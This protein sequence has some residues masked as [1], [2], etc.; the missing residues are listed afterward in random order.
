MVQTKPVLG[1]WNLLAIE[2]IVKTIENKSNKTD[3]AWQVIKNNMQV[4]P[5]VCICVS[6][7]KGMLVLTSSRLFSL[8]E[9]M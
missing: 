6:I 3:K 8:L 1:L 2:S 4:G 7:E 5:V 9:M